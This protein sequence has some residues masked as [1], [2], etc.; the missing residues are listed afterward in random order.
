MQKRL[1]PAIFG[2]GFA[3]LCALPLTNAA[4][5]KTT[6]PGFIWP[7][8]GTSITQ[9]YH[10]GYQAGDVFTGFPHTGIDIDGGTGDEIYASAKG[11]VVK[12]AYNAG[13]GSY[14]IVKHGAHWKTLYAHLDSVAVTEGDEVKKGDVIGSM[15]NTGRSTGDHLHFELRK[16]AAGEDSYHPVNPLNKI[17]PR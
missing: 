2:F 5:A 14:I 13:Y 1:I 16:K 11:T 9:Y 15:G 8:T 4:Q 7:T 6:T 10:V 3:L 12:T 17:S